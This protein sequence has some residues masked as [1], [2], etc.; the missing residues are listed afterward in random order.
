MQANF[1]ELIKR[2]KDMGGQNINSTSLS[3]CAVEFG[4][5]IFSAVKTVWLFINF[6]P[7]PLI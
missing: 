5:N 1:E 7:S 4:T 2:I 6:F 3:Y